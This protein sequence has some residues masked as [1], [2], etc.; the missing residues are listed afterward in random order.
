M[1]GLVVAVL[2]PIAEEAM[3]RLRRHVEVV[4]PPLEKHLPDID[5]IITRAS[6]VT[7]AMI[8]R[9]PRLRVI[10]KHGV[11]TDNIDLK[12]A[13]RQG[14]AVYNTPSANTGAVAELAVGLMLAVLRRIPAHDRALRTGAEPPMRIG[15]ELANARVGL[16]GL[17]TIACNLARLLTDGFGSEVAAHDPYAQP[18]TDLPVTLTGTLNGLCERS[19]ILSVHVPLT[20]E[21]KGLID[22]HVLSALPRGAIVI[23][24]ARGEVLDESALLAALDSGH[25]GGA[26]LDVLNSEPPDAQLPLFR[27]P[28]VVVTPHIGASTDEAMAR[29]GETIVTKVLAALGIGEQTEAPIQ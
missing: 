26:G 2:D 20:A 7:A 8:E 17:G 15:R 22:S 10:G 6:P 11:G 23:N 3:A 9:A 14:I 29:M 27:H 1:A 5:A 12:A 21:T 4:G 16:V 25:L 24:T 19:D 18:K 28:N 13:N